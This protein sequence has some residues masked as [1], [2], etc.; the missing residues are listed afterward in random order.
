MKLRLGL[1]LILLIA[2][3]SKNETPPAAY[4]PATP[5]AKIDP[6]TT[7]TISGVITFDG[8]APKA[9]PIDMSQD[10]AC[11]MGK[12]PPNFGEA[13]A[14]KAGHLQNVYIYIKDGLGN[15]S[16]P[17]PPPATLDQKGCRYVPHVLGLMVGQKLRILNSDPATHNIHSMAQTNDG[18]NES[19][20]PG[21]DAIEKTFTKPELMIPVQCNNHPWMKMYVNVS[22]HPFFSVSDAD[23]QFTISGLPPGAYTLAAVHE[24]MGEKTMQI[25][26]GAKESKTAEFKFSSADAK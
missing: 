7:S 3:C 20:F 13:Y 18:F 1:L 16:Y 25:T 14:V 19:Q 12:V 2:G 23:G 26:V 9:Q 21:S 17:A 5:T 4:K 10:P 15:Y 22:A 6:A 24:K 11:V 8:A